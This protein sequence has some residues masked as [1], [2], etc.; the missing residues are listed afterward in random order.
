VF[1]LVERAVPIP[2]IIV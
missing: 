1:P 2:M